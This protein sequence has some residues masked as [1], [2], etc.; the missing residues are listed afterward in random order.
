MRKLMI[1]KSEFCY[2]KCVSLKEPAKRSKTKLQKSSLYIQ[3]IK[4]EGHRAR[5][6]NPDPF[7]PKSCRLSFA[8]TARRRRGRERTEEK[9]AKASA[10]LCNPASS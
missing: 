10:K 9:H 4:H 2:F 6:P 8:S 5:Q 1:Y 7:S 3:F